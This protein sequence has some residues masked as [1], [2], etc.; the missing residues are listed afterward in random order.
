MGLDMYLTKKTY[1]KNWDHHKPEYRHE[2]TIKQ[3][4]KIRDDIK[5]ER[6]CYIEEE[7]AQWR[8]ANSIHKWFVD[9]VQNGKD[10]CRDYYVSH[11]QIAEPRAA[12]R[13]AAD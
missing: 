8:K 12:S 3:G 6:I 2:I 5:P 7:V 13:T 1:V 4:G 11:E 9:N 10:D